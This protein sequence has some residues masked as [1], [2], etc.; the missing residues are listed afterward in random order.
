MFERVHAMSEIHS[1]IDGVSLTLDV[2]D[3]QSVSTVLEELGKTIQTGCSNQGSCGSCLIMVK[4]KPRLA[5]TLRAK[6]LHRKT[7]ETIESIPTELQH[8]ITQELMRSGLIQCGYCLPGILRQ[9]GVLQQYMPN[10]SHEDIKKALNTHTCRCMSY[11]LIAAAIHRAFNTSIYEQDGWEPRLNRS[12][13]T[14]Q[15]PRVSQITLPNLQYVRLVFAPVIHERL[16]SVEAP[17][18]IT[19][20][21]AQTHPDCAFLTPLSEILNLD[22]LIGFVIADTK[23]EAESGLQRIIIHTEATSHKFPITE[24]TIPSSEMGALETECCVILDDQMYINGTTSNYTQNYTED[25]TL[26]NWGG[27]HFGHRVLTTHI[28]W[29]IWCATT[30]NMPIHLELSMAD[31]IRL[32]P[33]SPPV[34]IRFSTENDTISIQLSSTPEMTNWLKHTAQNVQAQFSH[35]LNQH[36]LINTN[37]N[38][39]SIWNH[40]SS[41]V[42]AQQ[43]LGWSMFHYWNQ[44]PSRVLEQRL[45]W[46]ETVTA[47]LPNLSHFKNG[48]L[49][50]F[51]G[52]TDANN[53]DQSIGWGVGYAPTRTIT[54][55][56][57]LEVSFY[58][59][60]EHDCILTMPIPDMEGSLASMAIQVLHQITGLPLERIHL[61]TSHNNPV[62]DWNAEY[63]RPLLLHSMQQLGQKVLQ[64]IQTDGLEPLRVPVVHSQ[65]KWQ[66]QGNACSVLLTLS[67]KGKVDAVDIMMDTGWTTSFNQA[68]ANISGLWMRALGTGTVPE[69]FVEVPHLYRNL[70][71]PKSKDTPNIEWN[72]TH[73]NTELLPWSMVQSATWMAILHAREQL[74]LPT[75]HLPFPKAAI[76]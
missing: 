56:Q 50:H 26:H 19:F 7:V 58:I 43:I 30:L 9:M 39:H 74:G 76:K 23:W 11:D 65:R 63:I 32:R 22:S 40:S 71:H 48:M 5:C 24:W 17:P 28:D 70:N 2:P 3:T 16:V 49:A 38:G 6:N 21:S 25:F 53:S 73:H 66:I 12:S 55:E 46:M 36:I 45:Q 42:V 44:E 27:G 35:I 41:Q 54:L 67:S 52:W 64:H 20:I 47:Q 57:P 72:L 33:K 18:D 61:N 10:P 69:S 59:T 13:V 62:P 51:E 1:T 68:K 15:R 31:A 60:S 14:G 8:A 29:A 34:V 75:S 4:G 37:T